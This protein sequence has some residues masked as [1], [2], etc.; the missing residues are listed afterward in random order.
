M[1]KILAL[2]IISF[3]IF[4]C[5][6]FN[7]SPVNGITTKN[8]SKKPLSKDFI[9]RWKID[10]HSY[11]LIGKEGYKHKNVELIIKNNGSFEAKN[12]PNFIDAFSENKIKDYINAEG[13]WKIGKDFDDEKWVLDLNFE[14]S[15]SYRDDLS[16]EFELYTEEEKLILWHFIGDPDSGE[17]L[18]FKKK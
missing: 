12:F 14:Q 5:K 8:L 1:K 6:Y 3:C 9:G 7:V 17:R 11:G 18:L 16:V 15:E 4:S 10:S 2:L 13:T